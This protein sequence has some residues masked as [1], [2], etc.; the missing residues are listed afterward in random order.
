[1][2]GLGRKLIYP[3]AEQSGFWSGETL[4]NRLA[5]VIVP[6]D[7]EQIEYNTYLL[8]VGSDIYV[9]PVGEKDAHTRTKHCL[10]DGEAYAIP[11]GQLALITPKRP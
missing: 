11:P 2:L 9:T 10:K 1:M 8:A 3:E 6:P 7:P 5:A 4:R